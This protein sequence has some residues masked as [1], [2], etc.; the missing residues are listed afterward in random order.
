[1]RVFT[2]LYTVVRQRNES[3][4]MYSLFQICALII[5]YF[6]GERIVKIGRERLKIL[7]KEKLYSFLEHSVLPRFY[8]TA[9][10]LWI[11][12][13]YSGLCEETRTKLRAL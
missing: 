2:T 13:K 7:Q 8:A 3:E 4:V 9:Q 11:S 12:T 1:M 6:D 5:S 10:K